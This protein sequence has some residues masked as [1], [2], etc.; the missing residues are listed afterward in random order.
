MRQQ[1][2]GTAV[3]PASDEAVRKPMDMVDVGQETGSGGVSTDGAGGPQTASPRWIPVPDSP[4]L[5]VQLPPEPSAGD[6]G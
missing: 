6:M 1:P 5:S 4:P 3:A 2:V